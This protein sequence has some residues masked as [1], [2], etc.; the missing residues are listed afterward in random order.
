MAATH[1]KL[2]FLFLI[3]SP[4][5]SQ[6]G[7]EIIAQ[8]TADLANLGVNVVAVGVSDSVNLEELNL[9]AT[10]PDSSNVLKMSDY[11]E[12][13]KQVN[14]ISE[15]AC[16]TEAPT[17]P[18]IT[19]PQTQSTTP[20]PIVTNA[21]TATPS[22][23]PAPITPPPIPITT[24]PPTTGPTTAT[25][26]RVPEEKCEAP[27]HKIGCFQ[28]D[29][30]VPRPLPELLFTD[31]DQTS[32]VSSGIALDWNNWS[33]YLTKLVC[34]CS[35]AARSKRYNFFSIQYYGECWSGPDAGETYKRNGVSSK[36]ITKEGQPCTPDKPD[37]CAGEAETNYVYGI[38]MP[39]E[40]TCDI[41]YEKLGCYKDSQQQPRPMNE[42]ILTD[43]DP[44]DP[45]YSGKTI[46]W[47]NW[48]TYLI[49]LVCRCA[50]KAAEKKYNYFGIQYFGECW[51]GAEAGDTFGRD[52]LADTCVTYGYNACPAD[53]KANTDQCAGKQF[54]NYVYGIRAA[55]PTCS[56]KYE[57]VG[58]YN[59]NHSD[60]RPLPQLILT[61]RDPTDKV[62][63]NVTIDWGN[64]DSYID[65]LI[66]RCAR[67]TQNKRFTYFGVQNYGECWSGSEAAETYNKD[68]DS[69]NCITD[70]YEACKASSTECVGKEKTNFVYKVPFS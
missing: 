10:D 68:G 56:V 8:P 27:F 22:T 31:R 7:I 55:A 25:P 67:V 28:D 36:C 45:V 34:R 42:L 64:W 46:D 3:W 5:F 43:R 62:Y 21:T 59:D 57:R 63:S 48:N 30:K 51:S 53:P 2:L 26:P 9:M 24:Q 58:C 41:P 16:P 70:G 13:L 29:M 11:D 1:M 44:T 37:V 32:P 6:S 54:T 15:I 14:K 47:G 19:Q 60:P 12:L 18:T 65:D 35:K 33:T 50:R 40:A 49:D 23:S 39:K 61:D 66:C 52:G 38:D 20:R 69:A 4:F 17:T